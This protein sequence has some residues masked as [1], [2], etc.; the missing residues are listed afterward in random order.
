[1]KPYELSPEQLTSQ[2]EDSCLKFEST[3]EVSPIDGVL[4]QDRALEAIAFGLG[5][6]RRGYNIYV[7]GNWGT[8]RNSYVRLLTEKAAEG[9]PIPKDWV[10]ANNFKNFRNPLALGFE[11]GEGKN[12][13]KSVDFIV[14]FLRKEVES[15]FS[16]K[17]YENAKAAI[18]TD[19]TNKTQSII[20]ALNEIG[21]KYGF[22]FGQNE[23]GLIS[24]PLRNGLPMTEEEYKSI[25]DEEYD[26]LK[27]NSGKLS[28]ETADIFNQLRD[29]EEQY[30]ANIKELDDS[31][32]RRI[33]T[34]HLMTLREKYAD[35][36]AVMTYFDYLVDDIVENLDNFKNEEEPENKS[37]FAMF[38]P[39]NTESFF[40]RY[41]LNLFVDNSETTTAPVVFASNPNYANL[42]GSIEYKN[43]MGVLRT[44]FTMIKPGALH[45]ANGGYLILLAKDILSM[46]YAWKSLKRAL[47]DENISIDTTGAQA[48]SI[49]SMTLNPQPIPLDVKIVLIG[50]QYTYQLL[51]YYDEEFRKLFK[52]MADFDIEMERNEDNIYKITQF[53]AKHCEEDHLKPFSKCAVAKIIE[54]SS[55]VADDQ[56]KLSSHLNKLV[57]VLYES[58]SWAEKDESEL[59]MAEHV[60]KAL[61][62]LN[63]RNNK[64][65]EK[66]LEMFDSGDYLL[67]VS[68][69]KVGE[70]NGLAVLGSGQYKFGKPSKITVSTYLGRSGLINIERE[71]RTSGAIH[72][73]GVMIISGY[74]GHMFAQ[75]RPISVTASIVF[76]QLYSGVD[77]DSASST[78]LYAILSSIA[79]L[80][81]TQSIAVTGSVNQRGE[82]Q[83]IGGVNEKIEGFFKVCK[84]K[85]LTGEQGVMIPQQNV[86]NL[87]LNHEVIEAV[88]NGQFHIYSVGHVEEGI[89]ILMGKKAGK[90]LKNG[91]FTKGSVFDLVDKKLAELAEAPKHGKKK[92]KPAEKKTKETAKK[93]LDNTVE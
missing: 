63:R 65:E 71:A 22:K 56:K 72:D 87:M 82:I 86:K 81:I 70:I 48:G 37:P 10:Y 32:G 60:D 16:G 78:E 29:E 3:A 19:Y 13:I 31:M 43:E 76:E 88:K 30:R 83:P 49:V 69:H 68:G 25:T 17:E 50:D 23:R 21:G 4:G 44:D 2:C 9:R 35:N 28:I 79:N 52:I 67:D 47:L 64:V 33:A 6:K 24:I 74:I 57:D 53:I 91:G 62:A 66:V 58:E 8:G 26:L 40:E 11:P 20:E 54:F 61:S 7:G 5:M 12:F 14:D 1:M 34:F 92:A 42:L 41:K 84:M 15:V 80:P 51:Y 46:P 39:R 90:V 75:T 73:K 36:Q 85:G 89:E 93:I 77:G 55:R 38:A 27:E 18:L 45:Q 59:V